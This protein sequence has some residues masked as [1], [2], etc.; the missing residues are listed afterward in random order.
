M[1]VDRKQLIE[2]I[3]WYLNGTLNRREYEEVEDFVNNDPEGRSALEDWR[4]VRLL[5]HV[6]ERK[7]PPAGIEV[8][9]FDRIRSQSLEQLGIFHPYALGLSLVI[10]VLLWAILRPGVILQW[11]MSDDQVTSF[12]I[13]RSEVDGSNYQLLDELPVNAS[14]S[15]CSYVDLFIWPL[16]E[17]IYYVEGINAIGGSGIS[18]VISSPALIALPGQL[19]LICASFFIGYGVVLLIHYRQ[20]LLIGNIRMSAV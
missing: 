9:I 8:R 3:P 7:T 15:D 1:M 20:L 11:R 16:K 12:R 14:G 17:Y 5:I 18:Q 4:R 6:E 19:A 10:L 2:L 13:Y